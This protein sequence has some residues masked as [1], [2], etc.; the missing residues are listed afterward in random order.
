MYAISQLQSDLRKLGIQPG[1]VLMVHAS[2]RSVGSTEGRGAGLIEALLSAV[3]QAGTLMA[4][5]AFEATSEVPG[6]DPKR[7][8]ARPS[9]GVFAELLRT[10]P[11]ASRSENPGASMVAVGA[12]AGWL[13]EE[14]PTSYGYGPDGP[15][16]KLVS[17][18]GKVLLLGSDPDQVTLL[19]LAEHLAAIPNKRV[20]TREVPVLKQD[21]SAS[22]LTVEEFDTSNPVVAGM[23]QRIFASIV[24][25][26]IATGVPAHGRVGQADA[27]LLPAQELVSFAV[28]IIE[29]EFGG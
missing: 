3:G 27:H 15:L 8:P 18:R 4:Y 9:Y 20:V 19:H 26:F 14:H 23:P 25:R 21:G 6:F 1:D 17:I 29:S 28:S 11:G 13:C 24:E 22:I 7:S 2:F 5:A 10:W 12:K 16:G